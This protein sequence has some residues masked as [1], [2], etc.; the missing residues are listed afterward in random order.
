MTN[1]EY[2]NSLDIDE[3]AKILSQILLCMD[4]PHEKDCK[5]Q[6]SNYQDASCRGELRAWLDKEVIEDVF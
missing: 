6:D 1:F 3:M 5:I 4:C 2:I